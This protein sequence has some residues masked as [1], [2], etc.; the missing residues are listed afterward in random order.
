MRKSSARN[1]NLP[2]LAQIL[3]LVLG[4]AACDLSTEADSRDSGDEFPVRANWSAS[5]A[6][7][8]TATVRG[9]L[10]IEEF[11][12]SRFIANTSI[13]GG[14]PNTAYQWRLFRGDCATT[15]VAAN[16]TAPT[17]LLLYGTVQAYPDLTTDATGAASV[18][19]RAMAGALDSLTAYSMR[20]RVA[21]AS[22]NWNGTSPVACGNLQRS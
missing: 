15:E 20:V 4:L 21:A 19:D 11:L 13:T 17:G 3:L 22:T 2:G 16:N 10:A 5:V 1:G 18:N 9:T 7:V 12:G 14:R 8:G 6:P